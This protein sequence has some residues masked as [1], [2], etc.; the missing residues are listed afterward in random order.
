M[1]G[2]FFGNSGTGEFVAGPDAPVP[3]RLIYYPNNVAAT[4][5]TSPTEGVVGQSVKVAECSFLLDGSAFTGWN[6]SADGRGVSYSPGDQYVLSGPENYLYAQW[7]SGD[8]EPPDPEPEDARA[9]WA[10]FSDTWGTISGYSASKDTS[11]Y[12]NTC[13]VLYEY[14]VPDSFDDDGMPGTAYGFEVDESDSMAAV[15]A[16]SVRI[17]YHTERGYFTETIKSGDE[18]DIET[19]LDKRGDSPEC[20]SLWPR[21]AVTVSL[22]EDGGL[23]RQEAYERAL[24]QLMAKVNEGSK[25]DFKSAYEGWKK[26][27]QASGVDHLRDNYYVVTNLD[28]GTVSTEGYMRDFDLGDKVDMAVSRVGLVEVARIVEVEESYES[29]G[30]SVNTNIAVTIGD[31]KLSIIKK[32]SLAR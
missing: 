15:S 21:D 31:S 28:S 5:D 12:K 16:V 23:T 3:A 9:P 13:F 29:S 27:L 4:G 11:N 19:Y 8:P 1:S 26:S 18:P 17:P 7:D 10:V 2:R 24:D 30:N 25:Y 20:D 32:A 22:S 6:T 14:E